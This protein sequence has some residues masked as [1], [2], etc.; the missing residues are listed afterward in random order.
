MR[1][2]TRAHPEGLSCRHL[3][4]PL[5]PG[6]AGLEPGGWLGCRPAGSSFLKETSILIFQ[7]WM[8]PTQIIQNN[9]YLFYKL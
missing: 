2:R 5:G 7:L 4:R 9:L 6:W 8:R 1:A 3:Q